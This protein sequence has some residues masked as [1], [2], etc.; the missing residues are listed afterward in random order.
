MAKAGPKS[1]ARAT[2]T[3]PASERPKPGS[4]GRGANSAETRTRL[5]D[6]AIEALVTD[7]Y[8]SASAR[9]IAGRAGCNQAVIYYHFGSVDDLLS[10]AVNRSGQARLDRYRAA[11]DG[12]SDP[13][14]ILGTWRELHREDIEIGHIPALVQLLGG[15]ASSETLRTGLRDA[16]EPTTAFIRETIERV[17]AA[18]GLEAIVPVDAAADAVFSLYLGVELLTLV[19]G[20]TERPEKLLSA[21]QRFADQASQLFALLGVAPKP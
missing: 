19:D 7:G 1:K 14:A 13:T 10:Q 18:S 20:D 16:V 6:A 17:I 3:T 9:A 15:V 2:G 21:G 8:A 5:L 12:L 4:S 11:M